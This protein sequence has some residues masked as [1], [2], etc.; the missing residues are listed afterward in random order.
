MDAER[1]VNM[2]MHYLENQPKDIRE[3]LLET[4][5]QR[6][7]TEVWSTRCFVAL[8]ACAVVATIMLVLTQVRYFFLVM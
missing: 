3:E 5:R 4:E 8:T 1:F 7:R 2:K 6:R